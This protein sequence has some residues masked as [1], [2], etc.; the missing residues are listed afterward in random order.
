MAQDQRPQKELQNQPQPKS[1]AS[2]V[3]EVLGVTFPTMNLAVTGSDVPNLVGLPLRKAAEIL[4]A[5]GVV[6]ALKGAGLVVARQN[7]AP[8]TAWSAVEKEPFT[9]W[10]NK[11]S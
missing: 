11:A 6:P 7:P 1:A 9:L 8:G 2:D 3:A 4:A 10:M 5:K